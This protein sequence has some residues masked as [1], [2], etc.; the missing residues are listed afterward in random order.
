MTATIVGDT[1]RTSES[2]PGSRPPHTRESRFGGAFHEWVIA[3]PRS[4]DQVAYRSQRFCYRGRSRWL[5][6]PNSP[7]HCIALC[8]QCPPMAV[9]PSSPGGKL[10]MGLSLMHGLAPCPHVPYFDAPGAMNW[11]G[12]LK[13]PPNHV[14]LDLHGGPI[15]AITRP[16]RIFHRYACFGSFVEQRRPMFAFGRVVRL[17]R[18]LAP[19]RSINPSSSDERECSQQSLVFSYRGLWYPF[20]CVSREFACF[21]SA[22]DLLTTYLL[23]PNFLDPFSLLPLT[24]HNHASDL[25]S[26]AV[27]SSTIFPALV[28]ASPS[29]TGSVFQYT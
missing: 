25:V 20:F 19:P 10:F 29:F 12:S 8:V 18:E 1:F 23:I 16:F 5:H 11:S 7:C 2:D 15:E 6:G 22:A 4:N 24:L 17:C 13:S 14:A 21:F 9:L 27:P 28:Y 3:I 26:I